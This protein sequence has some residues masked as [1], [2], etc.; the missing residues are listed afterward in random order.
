M[1]IE[2]PVEPPSE[3]GGWKGL[4]IVDCD[5]HNEPGGELAKY[6]PK[7]WAEY[8]RLIGQSRMSSTQNS[9]VYGM[10]AYASRLDSIPPSG[11]I[12]GSDPE[13]AREQ[14]LDEYGLS[15]AIINNISLGSGNVPLEFENAMV[16]AVNDY[17]EEWLDADP[18]WLASISA[19]RVDPAWSA[20]ELVRCREKSDRYVQ[21]LLQAVG[22]RP[23]GN[24]VYWP[25]Y[26]AA[27]E[28]DIPVAFHIGRTQKPW[29]STGTGPGSFYYEMRTSLDILGQTIV[30]SMIFE[31]VFDR[32]PQLRIALIEMDWTWVVPFAWR[33]D[34]AWRVL[35]DEVPELQL[36]PSEYLRRHFWFSTQPALDTEHHA[37]LAQ[38]YGQLERGGFADRLMFATD[39]P[40]WDMDSPFESTPKG[41]SPEMKRKILSGN[42]ASLYNL[43][44]TSVE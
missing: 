11:G 14:L 44:L 23:A 21:A 7:R 27:A 37:Q 19:S 43:K 38:V 1:A 2:L 22:E 32:W 13:F 25:I 4:P 41:L 6:L 40:H 20:K 30:S 12:P 35:R 16:R 17:N 36:K 15:A 31:G 3:A 18:R 29:M 24:P 26:E 42:A 28:L 5:V 8:M 9:I 33:L 34:S 10:H 39:Y